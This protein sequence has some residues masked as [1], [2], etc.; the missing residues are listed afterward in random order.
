MTDPV[1][2]S[3]ARG[4]DP[5]RSRALL[6]VG[7]A[8]I[9]VAAIA[10]VGWFATRDSGD[11]ADRQAQVEARGETVMPFDQELTTHVFTATADGGVQ[12]V[13]ANDPSDIEQIR[14]V[15]AHLRT[16]AARFASGN[17]DDPAA[18]HGMDMPGLHELRAGATHIDVRYSDMPDGGRIIYS[19]DDPALVT[20]L[21]KWFDAQLMDH[22][23]HAHE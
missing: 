20:A 2:I 10:V 13:T 3:D 17:F 21:H 12:S 11:R 23:A 18:I 8:G 4:A 1:P 14:L 22:G 9:L 15:R 16:E 19:T 5:R 6:F 7:G